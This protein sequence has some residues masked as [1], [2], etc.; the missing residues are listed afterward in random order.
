MVELS[1][2]AQA[3]IGRKDSCWKFVVAAV[4][5]RLIAERQVASC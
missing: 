2:M 3:R 5:A 4:K 1:E